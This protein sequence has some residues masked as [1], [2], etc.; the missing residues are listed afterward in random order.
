M[1]YQPQ[2]SVTPHLIKIIEEISALREQI[3]TATIQVPW[4]PAL[5]KD[6]WVRNTHSSTAIEGNPL[7]LEEVKLLAEAKELPLA[8]KRSRQEI[9]N[10]FAGLRFIEKSL[11]KKTITKEDLLHLHAVMA[12][13]VMDQGTHGL[14][15]TLQVRVGNYFPPPPE[16][17]PTLM[18]EFLDWWNKESARWSPVISS[19]ILHYRFEEIHPF[20]DGNGRVGRALA[21]W[22]LYRRGFDTHHIF[23]VDEVYWENRP[24]Y[25]QA[26]QLIQHSQGELSSWLE[27]VAEAIHLTLERVWLRVKTYSEKNLEQKVMLT[28]KQERLLYLL[29]ERG[30]MAPREIWQTL[31]LSKQGALNLINP[32]V[33]AGLV[34]R[35]GT[36]KSGKYRLE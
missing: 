5:Q 33:K 4:L 6:A 32:L 24:R 11:H 18:V 12:K 25:Y 14:Y 35:E 8:T 15:R 20:A 21:L 30:A 9:L 10:Y 27:F 22:D 13:G 16:T 17:V 19:A 34:V 23:S 29:R 36:R 3:T 1:S 7:S 2:F 28:P 26:L 31:K